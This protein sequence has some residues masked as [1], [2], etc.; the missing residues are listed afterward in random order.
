MMS[1]QL[2]EWIFPLATD[3]PCRICEF[4]DTQGHYCFLKDMHKDSKKCVLIDQ[5][6]SLKVNGYTL[7]GLIDI[8]EQCDNGQRLAVVRNE[9]KMPENPFHHLA[10]TLSHNG[11]KQAQQEM[12]EAGFVMEL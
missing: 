9:P 1:E 5:I 3:P 12:L 11:Y 6:L 4:W 7:Q 10:K 2:R 8:A